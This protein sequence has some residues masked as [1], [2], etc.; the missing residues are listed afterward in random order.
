M[1]EYPESFTISGQINRELSGST[2]TSCIR[3]NHPHKFAFYNLDKNEYESRI[4]GKKIIGSTNRH[5][6]ILIS[7]N[8][9]LVLALG[10][11]GEKITLHKD[12]SDIPTKH[13]LLLGFDDGRFMSV[14]VAG[15]GMV[16]LY[17]QKEIDSHPYLSKIRTDPQDNDFSPDKLALMVESETRNPS[18]KF[19]LIS[20]PGISGIGNGMCQEILFEAGLHPKTK[21]KSL[22]NGDIS[23][24]HRAITGI[25]K[26]A[27]ELGGRDNETD[28]YGDTGRFQTRMTSKTVGAPCPNC[29]TPIEKIS[30]LGGNCYFCPKCQVQK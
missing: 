16:S 30:W 3:D 13:Q 21:I 17:T 4:I 25:T 15:W 24:L 27:C 6:Y 11:G 23:G 5:S 26:K 10:E 7:L 14:T 28:I 19:F 9:D 8:C 22:N 20:D 12:S 18:A 2:I 1:I 29:G